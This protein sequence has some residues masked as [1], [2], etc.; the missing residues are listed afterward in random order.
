MELGPL[1]NGKYDG[2][3][4]PNF[5]GEKKLVSYKHIGVLDRKVEPHFRIQRYIRVENLTVRA[6]LFASLAV[7]REA[8]CPE[9]QFWL[10]IS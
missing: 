6:Y 9:S 7:L 10:D 4:L 1:S 2:I 3:F 8:L 5:R